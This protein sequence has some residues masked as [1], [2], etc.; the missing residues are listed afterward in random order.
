MRLVC[1]SCGACHSA[2]AWVNDAHAR[3]A[4]GI[5]VTLPPPVA[6]HALGYVALF[7]NPEAKRG[8]TWKK[9]G[10]L[11]AELRDMVS[12][13]YVQYKR[14][15]ARP[16]TPKIWGEA[17]ETMLHSRSIDPPLDGH[18]Y[19]RSVAYDLAD[20]ADRKTEV[21][22][23]QAERTGNPDRSGTSVPQPLGEIVDD[24]KQL[25]ERFYADYKKRH[26]EHK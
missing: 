24:E 26:K 22:R 13:G 3:R 4:L 18:N 17:L 1:P 7:R 15:P 11:L 25:R 21:A 6:P 20:A 19:L 9:A 23:N 8:L 14:R 16:A 5:A 12:D 10:R 2:D